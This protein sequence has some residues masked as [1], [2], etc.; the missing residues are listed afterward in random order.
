MPNSS[1]GADDWLPTD[2]ELFARTKIWSNFFSKYNKEEDESLGIALDDKS[3][4]K[5]LES[6]DDQSKESVASSDFVDAEEKEDPNFDLEKVVNQTM[7]VIEKRKKNWGRSGFDKLM[8]SSFCMD[9]YSKKVDNWLDGH[10]GFFPKE[11]KSHRNGGVPCVDEVKI[12]D[13][14]VYVEKSSSPDSDASVDTVKYI[15]SNTKKQKTRYRTMT[16]KKYCYS[17]RRME[18]LEQCC[19][20][21]VSTIYE[22]S[23][24]DFA[25]RRPEIPGS[26]NYSCRTLNNRPRY[27]SEPVKQK[28]RKRHR[29]K[30]IELPSDSS[31]S[32]DYKSENAGRQVKRSCY[33]KSFPSR[34]FSTSDDDSETQNS[35]IGFCPENVVNS[36]ALSNKLPAC[37]SRNDLQSIPEDNETTTC[38]NTETNGNNKTLCNSEVKKKP[39]TPSPIVIYTPEDTSKNFQSSITKGK[40]ILTSKMLEESIGPELT[41]VYLNLNKDFSHE[42]DQHSKIL[43]YPPEEVAETSDSEADILEQISSNRTGRIVEILNSK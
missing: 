37:A 26:T 29:I 8:E 15:L 36:T 7:K 4:V 41:K 18:E 17:R 23:L 30:S 12:R 27:N 31:S 39:P 33:K 14:R 13:H 21:R 11:Y 24:S 5:H 25:G 42:F 32:P 9:E 34:E 38:N 19:R 16:I 20:K 22:E 43:F 40:I 6:D 35:E 2:D 1:K 10:S 28:F 3:M